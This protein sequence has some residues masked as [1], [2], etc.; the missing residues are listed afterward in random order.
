MQVPYIN[1][2]SESL[3]C[4]GAGGTGARGVARCGPGRRRR[5]APA[6]VRGRAPACAGVRRR[7]RACAHVRMCAGVRTPG[8]AALFSSQVAPLYSGARGRSPDEARAADGTAVAKTIAMRRNHKIISN[9]AR[10][11]RGHGRGCVC[12]KGRRYVRGVQKPPLELGAT[13]PVQANHLEAGGVVLSSVLS[14]CSATGRRVTGRPMRH[15]GTVSVRVAMRQATGCS[16]RHS[17]SAPQPLCKP[18]TSRQANHL[19]AGGVALS[20]VEVLRDWAQGDRATDAAA[21]GHR[22]G[23]RRER[24]FRRPEHTTSTRKNELLDI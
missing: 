24:V 12:S 20:I 22:V 16:T 15:T 10:C 4:V 1:G 18:T 5:C 6:C 14:R 3:R 8:R 7:M 9:T 13:A 17:S 21:H 23:A 19:E 2:G 11:V